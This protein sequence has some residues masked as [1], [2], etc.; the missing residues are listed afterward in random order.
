MKKLNSYGDEFIEKVKAEGKWEDVTDYYQVDSVSVTQSQTN[1]L[2]NLCVLN[3][4]EWIYRYNNTKYKL[5]I[6]SEMDCNEIFTIPLSD[7]DA[8]KKELIENFVK[9]MYSN[10]FCY[11]IK[12]ITENEYN[13][14]SDISKEEIENR[15]KKAII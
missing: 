7:T 13:Q 5:D 10:I 15:L 11:D 6:F 12:E 8:K 2:I 4:T 3:H 9:N 1:F 14:S